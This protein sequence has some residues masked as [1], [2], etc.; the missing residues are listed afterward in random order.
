MVGICGL[1]F[2]QLVIPYPAGRQYHRPQKILDIGQMQ[3]M[4]CYLW[5]TLGQGADGASCSVPE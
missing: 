1:P 2:Y 5:A 3:S 4:D